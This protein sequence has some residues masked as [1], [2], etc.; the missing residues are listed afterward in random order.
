MERIIIDKW[1]KVIGQV[2]EQLDKF[3][4]SLINELEEHIENLPDKEIF[5]RARQSADEIRE[6]AEKLVDLSTDGGEGQKDNR[7]LYFATYIFLRYNECVLRD[8]GQ[9][10]DYFIRSLSELNRVLDFRIVE[11]LGTSEKLFISAAKL[12]FK[13]HD[14]EKAKEYAE[15]AIKLEEKNGP[16]T[17]LNYDLRFQKR[18]LLAYCYEY[19]YDPKLSGVGCCTE[20]KNG[21]ISAVKLLIG[22]RPDTLLP[23]DEE[24][25]CAL[26]EIIKEAQASPENKLDPIAVIDRIYNKDDQTCLAYRIFNSYK[27]YTKDEGRKYV[28]SLAH[29]LA[30]C[31]SELHKWDVL[32]ALQRA[33]YSIY[34]SRMAEVLMRSVNDDDKYITCVSTVLLEN[35]EYD[36]AIHGMEDRRDDLEKKWGERERHELAQVDFYIWYFSVITKRYANPTVDKNLDKK[37]ETYK[38]KFEEYTIKFPD[39]KQAKIYYVLLSMKEL[40]MRCF[41]GLKIGYVQD[42][43]VNKLLTM[44]EE[45]S[46]LQP[47]KSVHKAIREEWESLSQ[48]SRIF[49]PCYRYNKT[50]N[51]W[52]LFDIETE[53][54]SF[55]IGEEE[56]DF[57]NKPNLTNAGK[58]LSVPEREKNARECYEISWNQGAFLY[59]GRSQ[60]AAHEILVHLGI[61]YEARHE[62]SKK[63]ISNGD[64]IA[65]VLEKNANILFIYNSVNEWYLQE[66][67]AHIEQNGEHEKKNIFLCANDGVPLDGLDDFIKKHPFIKKMPNLKTAM[68]Y[69]VLFSAL[70][71]CI[72]RVNKPLE[73]LIISPIGT[74]KTYSDQ[75]FDE[76]FFLTKEDMG[77]L[78]LL[79]RTESELKDEWRADFYACS[80]HDDD[81]IK[82]KQITAKAFEGLIDVKEHIDFILLVELVTDS[83]AGKNRK[84]S[85]VV[86]QFKFDSPFP[87]RSIAHTFANKDNIMNPGADNPVYSSLRSLYECR[88][89]RFPNKVHGSEC[90]SSGGCHSFFYNDRMMSETSVDGSDEYYARFAEEVAL[91]LR[92]DIGKECDY[93]IVKPSN[94]KS[95]IFCKFK[96]NI[97]IEGAKYCKALTTHIEDVKPSD[98][99]SETDATQP[100]ANSKSEQ[101]S[102]ST[103]TSSDATT[104]V[105]AKLQELIDDKIKPTIATMKTGIRALEN[106]HEYSYQVVEAKKDLSNHV[107]SLLRDIRSQCS[108]KESCSKTLMDEITTAVDKI[109]TSWEN[110]LKQ[111]NAIKEDSKRNW[112]TSLSNQLAMEKKEVEQKIQELKELLGGIE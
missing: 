33:Q 24:G 60:P 54:L 62:S 34:L 9:D 3:S 5:K 82:M 74:A 44:R 75:N 98:V 64:K 40:L 55:S 96:P 16:D 71:R 20:Q 76:A 77:S 73:T 56:D 95:F 32:G 53:I 13:V 105:K 17:E 48:A 38:K 108:F 80:S 57:A 97:T 7:V 92:L 68:Q 65:E 23:A 79:D 42:E 78:E 25:T 66:I 6:R 51:D 10:E 67:C 14:Y 110:G 2:N 39:D 46:G 100:I 90:E 50:W 35:E 58:R 37:I 83:N 1:R 101:K 107:L 8:F 93:A 29:V 84:A 63:M 43:L 30:H 99:K 52:Y 36:L 21:L 11:K 61:K 15:R 69:C 26:K 81:K 112:E 70:E 31:F 103:I 109:E 4:F 85:T 59:M 22:F 45:F 111:I 86:Y 49:L 102:E 94:D 88:Q 72:Y 91:Y 18:C 104:E 28:C 87:L 47:P 41:K 27:R 106:P 12:N 89:G 19:S